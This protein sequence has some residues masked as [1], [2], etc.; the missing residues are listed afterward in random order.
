MPL[1]NANGSAL[2]YYLNIDAGVSTAREIRI[3]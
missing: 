1:N 2:S 3:S